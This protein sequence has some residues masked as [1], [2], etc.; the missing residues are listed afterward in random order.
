[1][2]VTLLFGPGMLRKTLPEKALRHA[3]HTD[4]QPQEIEKGM[5]AFREPL[6]NVWNSVWRTKMSDIAEEHNVHVELALLA[7]QGA[8]SEIRF[9]EANEINNSGFRD[10][11]PVLLNELN[12]AVYYLS[13]IKNRASFF[14]MNDYRITVRHQDG[15][16][17]AYEKKAASVTGLR[18]IGDP[19]AETIGDTYV[20]K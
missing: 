17:S 2:K 18:S 8:M 20:Q 10:R 4:T 5:G 1:M 3:S 13:N 9:I 12:K 15:K 16:I 14:E 6:V 7:L 11:F 19:Q